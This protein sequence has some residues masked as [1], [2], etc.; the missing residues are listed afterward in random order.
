MEET[1][2]YVATVTSKGQVTIPA[3]VREQLGILP[4]D[5]VIFRVID[6]N[7]LVVEPLPMT[8][9]EV[10]GSVPALQQPEDFEA[11]IEIVREERAE[12]YLRKWTRR[13]E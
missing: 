12:Q 5:K 1:V 3:A 2:E 4:Q 6:G 7:R 13:T 9:E 10:Y 8:L 11:M